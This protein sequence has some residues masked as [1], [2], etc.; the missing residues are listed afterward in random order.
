MD[1]P[2][3]KDVSSAMV[4][5]KN[6]EAHTTC[7]NRKHQL[8]LE[9]LNRYKTY[10]K[11]KSELDVSYAASLQRLSQQCQIS[12][13]LAHAAGYTNRS[14]YATWNSYLNESLNV[15]KQH[16][17]LG[18]FIG[19]NVGEN[20]KNLQ[21]IKL[22]AAKQTL[23]KLARIHQELQLSAK[24]VDRARREYVAA[25]S[26]HHDVSEKAKSLKEKLQ[27][28]QF[29]LFQ[30]KE[31]VEAEYEKLSTRC[32]ELRSLIDDKRN[33]YLLQTRALSEHQRR[34]RSI[35]MPE[36]GK[37]L[38]QG[39]YEQ[40]WT[41]LSSMTIIEKDLYQSVNDRMAKMTTE[42]EQCMSPMD[43]S[44]AFMASDRSLTT[45]VAVGFEQHPHDDGSTI[46]L[47]KYTEPQL[48]QEAKK[49]VAAV[50]RHKRSI[51]EHEPKLAQ[52]EQLEKHSWENRKNMGS[53][54]NT[55]LEELTKQ[56]EST[57]EMLRK[58][59]TALVKAQVIVDQLREAGVRL[60]E[61][62]TYHAVKDPTPKTPSPISTIRSIP[63][64][65]T[66]KESLHSLA[67]TTSSDY[68]T[69]GRRYIAKYA[70]KSVQE[71]EL[72]LEKGEEILVIENPT[73]VQWPKAQNGDGFVGVVPHN[74]IEPAPVAPPAEHSNPASQL[75]AGRRHSSFGVAQSEDKKPLGYCEALL[76][77]D[78]SSNSELS[79]RFHDLIAILNR[80]PHQVD[81]GW[82]S[83]RVL[84]SGKIGTF[85]SLMV[86]E[87]SVKEADERLRAI[88]CEPASATNDHYSTV[89]KQRPQRPPVA[90]KPPRATWYG[91]PPGSSDQRQRPILPS[92]WPAPKPN[93][94]AEQRKSFADMTVERF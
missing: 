47:N 82:W 52:L 67:S 5:K 87:L 71:D 11:Q 64:M 19:A 33:A 22:E 79:A 3:R 42:V 63:S 72:S 43:H 1:P 78:A 34:Y 66:R 4:F 65:I 29:G 91:G 76:D 13:H 10:C 80:R 85:A 7:F 14:L 74:Y 73:D 38:E 69:I 35:D 21:H 45:A 44:E 31:E 20:L 90:K 8:E 93:L 24:E 54:S 17:D 27:K 77:M 53:S 83:G 59:Q 18:R 9:F 94:N 40:I 81:D 6:Q 57:R 32:E 51:E 15:A 28:K 26:S 88:G 50:A 48:N 41:Y 60:E 2:P 55:G 58:E 70:Y 39:I 16:D 84:P 56:I 23:D 61:L 12:E 37:T 86:R 30:K 68:G 25:C 36:L 89:A 62:T 75:N 49:W 92:G 46:V